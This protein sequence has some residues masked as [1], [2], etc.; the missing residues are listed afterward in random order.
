MNWDAIG[1]I[2]ETIG[3]AGVIVSL[4]YLAIQIR[5]D[6]GAKRAA[7][8]HEQQ[9]AYRGFLHMMA[10]NQEVSDIYIKGI[11]DFHSLETTELPRFTS[12]VGYLF[13]IFEENFFLW[14]D[15]QLEKRIWHGYVSPIGDSLNYPGVQAWWGTRSH[16][17][18][19]EFRDFIDLKIKE[20]GEPNLYG[21]HP[22]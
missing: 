10:T 19:L 7:T 5:G 18:S 11:Q 21:E 15:G 17:Y 13:R 6:A 16:W 3:A 22:N 9:E 2:A 14:K 8:I 1:A 12:I 4:L 20:S